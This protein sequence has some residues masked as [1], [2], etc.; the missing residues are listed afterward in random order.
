VNTFCRGLFGT[1]G[2]PPVEPHTGFIVKQ[3]SYCCERETHD[4]KIINI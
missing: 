1:D 2:R 3:C 4:Q